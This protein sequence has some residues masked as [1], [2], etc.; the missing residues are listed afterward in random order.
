MSSRFLINNSARKL[1]RQFLKSILECNYQT[2]NYTHLLVSFVE[3][4]RNECD[5]IYSA[6]L[7]PNSNRFERKT[8]MI[9][10]IAC[11]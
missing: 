5:F 11:Y 6:Y 10:L 1:L 8:T 2:I 4:F 9:K 3:S 7:T